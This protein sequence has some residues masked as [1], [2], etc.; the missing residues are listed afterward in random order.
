MLF[1][2]L[3]SAVKISVSVILALVCGCASTAHLTVWEPAKVDVTGMQ[4]IAVFDFDGPGGQILAEKLNDELKDAKFYEVVDRSEWQPQAQE[5]RDQGVPR[6]RVPY[7]LARKLELD[8][9]IVGKVARYEVNDDDSSSVLYENDGG[10]DGPGFRLTTVGTVKREGEVD[11]VIR[12]YEVKTGRLRAEE[13][14]RRTVKD[15]AGEGESLPSAD[16]A[17]VE[18]TDEA[19]QELVWKLTPHRKKVEVELASASWFHRNAALIRKANRHAAKEEWEQA[20]RAWSKVLAADPDN[21][22]VKYNLALALEAQHKYD[23]S[24]KLMTELLTSH[25]QASYQQT[26]MRMR[27]AKNKHRE[28]QQQKLALFQ[29]DGKS[30][31]GVRTASNK[32]DRSGFEGPSEAP[33]AA[34]P[35]QNAGFSQGSSGDPAAQAATSAPTAP[36]RTAPPTMNQPYDP[37]ALGGSPQ[38][39]QPPPF[40]A[41]VAPPKVP[42]QPPAADGPFSAAQPSVPYQP[43]ATSSP[44]TGPYQVPDSPQQPVPYQPPGQPAVSQS[45]SPPDR[46]P[47][48]AQQPIPY[49]PGQTAPPAGQPYQ[50]P[51][52]TTPVPY[53]PPGSTPPSA[54]PGE[55][56]GPWE[57]P[58]SSSADGSDQPKP[59]AAASDEQ[60]EIVLPDFGD[61]TPSIP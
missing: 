29:G 13:S 40:A 5:L 41:E 44:P 15:K 51:S 34:D 9:L 37:A 32:P 24:E 58:A 52:A 48:A 43:P 2:H 35:Q 30:D 56:W 17:L 61:F 47:P 59:D 26:L 1:R 6:K 16:R 45:S 8:G 49:Q 54:A 20:E 22:A 55:Q 4:R 50:V 12:L 27:E 60:P 46:T 39:D 21:Q 38:A 53:Q 28:A 57:P 33:S 23:Q 19:V 14:A 18:L 3:I 42:Y 11:V 25:P 31:D 36:P 10:E 7:E